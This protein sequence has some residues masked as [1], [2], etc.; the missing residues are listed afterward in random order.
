ME[1]LAA[2]LWGIRRFAEKGPLMDVVG[3]P[4]AIVGPNEAG[5]TTFLRSLHRLNT[6][7]PIP[8]EEL[9]RGGNDSA[10]ITAVFRLGTDDLAAIA[11][12]PLGET[13]R[14][15]T[16]EKHEDGNSRVGLEPT[17]RRDL[18]LLEST[19]AATAAFLKS[20]WPRT[21]LDDD[22][23]GLRRPTRNGFHREQR[24]RRSQACSRKRPPGR[25]HASS[26]RRAHRPA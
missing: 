15:M 20:G 17:P 23:D 25:E 19:R 22:V 21:E 13:P 7:D 6:D 14:K 16:V 2:G 5:K 10:Q 4:I 12:L 8:P 18:A 26:P 24:W 9:T 11:H 1:L 3:S